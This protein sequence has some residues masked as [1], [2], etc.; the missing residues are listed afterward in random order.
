MRVRFN[1]V[2]SRLLAQVVLLVVLDTDIRLGV[3]AGLA[4]LPAGSPPTRHWWSPGAGTTGSGSGRPTASRWSGPCW[5]AASRPWSSTAP[6]PHVP[7]LVAL[8]TSRCC[9]TASTGRWRGAPAPRR[10]SAARFDMEVDAFLILVLSVVRRPVGRP[11]GAADRAARYLLLASRAVLLP[12]AAPSGAGAL[13]GARWSPRSRASCSRSPR[14]DVL[15][16]VA[17]ASCCS[18]VALALLAESFGRQVWWLWHRQAARECAERPWAAAPRRPPAGSSRRD[19]DGARRS[20][21]CGS[22]LTAPDRA[23]S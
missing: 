14:P 15:P 11:V 10:R 8:A 17:D 21:W 6:D 7:V 3:P 13:L 16:A 12:V 19:A 9:S 22:A 1:E 5:S 20:R 18:S 4:G 2:R 23:A